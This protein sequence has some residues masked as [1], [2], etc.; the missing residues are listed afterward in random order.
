MIGNAIAASIGFCIEA[1]V[2]TVRLFIYYQCDDETER[3][4]Y[5]A[6]KWTITPEQYQKRMFQAGFASL[7]AFVGSIVGVAVA[8]VIGCGVFVP[9]LLVGFFGYLVARKLSSSLYD[10][11]KSFL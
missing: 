7:A 9:S 11:G 5:V 4:R 6:Q 2:L 1:V 10:K 3:Q 8:G